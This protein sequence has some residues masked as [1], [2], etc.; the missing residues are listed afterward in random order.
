MKGF[1]KSSDTRRDLGGISFYFFFVLRSI[2]QYDLAD[3]VFGYEILG[4]LQRRC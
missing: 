2:D 4:M 1:E 3:I